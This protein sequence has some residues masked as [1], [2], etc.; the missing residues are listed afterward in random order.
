MYECPR[1]TEAFTMERGGT[2]EVDAGRAAGALS[3][4]A[5]ILAILLGIGV[6]SYRYITTANRVSSEINGW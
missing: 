3:T 4:V 2:D 1:G 6:P 5:M